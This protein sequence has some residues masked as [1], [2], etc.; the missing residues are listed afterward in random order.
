MQRLIEEWTP[1]T[2]VIETDSEGAHDAAGAFD[3][4]GPG[5]ARRV[6]VAKYGCKS[7]LAVLLLWFL[8]KTHP[9]SLHCCLLL[10]RSPKLPHKVYWGRWL[11]STEI[12]SGTW[13]LEWRGSAQCAPPQLLW[14]LDGPGSFARCSRQRMSS[15]P[16]AGQK[17]AALGW[18]WRTGTGPN[19]HRCR[20]SPRDWTKQAGPIQCSVRTCVLSRLALL[21]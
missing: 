20:T 8:W 3:K 19:V 4:D 9:W 16:S 13:R 18:C 1:D 10:S 5:L 6:R 14:R 11:T 7:Y 2:V 12:A 21:G 17:R 15:V